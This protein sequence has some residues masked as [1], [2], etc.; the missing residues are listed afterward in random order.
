MCR[1][2][3][4]VLK[5]FVTAL[6]TGE[7]CVSCWGVPIRVEIEFSH[8]IAKIV[9]EQTGILFVSVL[10]L[11]KLNLLGT[12]AGGLTE[13]VGKV[14]GG[15]ELAPVVLTLSIVRILSTVDAGFEVRVMTGSTQ[16]VVTAVCRVAGTLVVTATDVVMKAVLSNKLLFKIDW[17]P[18]LMFLVGPF[19]KKASILADRVGFLIA[20]SSVGLELTRFL[21][22]AIGLCGLGAS[23][24][25]SIAS[26]AGR[27]LWILRMSDAPKGWAEVRIEGLI[28]SIL[29]DLSKGCGL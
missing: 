6:L 12:V 1:C 8:V 28:R 9:C 26:R 19:E 4:A 22:E 23:V 10:G 11:Q 24:G 7:Y 27:A 21:L 3:C 20:G 2:V 17:S 16:S 15:R 5:M 13:M 18:S 14:V 25:G 29:R